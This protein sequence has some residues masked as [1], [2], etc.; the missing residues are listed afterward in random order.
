MNYICLK[1]KKKFYSNINMSVYASNKVHFFVA[2]KHRDNTVRTLTSM[3]AC[4][5]ILV[6]D[7]SEVLVD[8]NYTTDTL[9]IGITKQIINSPLISVFHRQICNI[10]KLINAFEKELHWD[11]KSIIFKVKV[12]STTNNYNKKNNEIYPTYS[13]ILKP[14]K[15]WLCLIPYTHILLSL[16]RLYNYSFDLPNNLNLPII[17]HFFQDI[18]L[19]G[20]D[21]QD[22][23]IIQE[24]FT[25]LMLLLYNMEDLVNESSINEHWDNWW[26]SIGIYYLGCGNVTIPSTD[27]TSINC[28]KLMRESGYLV[29]T[30]NSVYKNYIGKS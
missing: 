9:C 22:L 30:Y 21:S 19:V 5:E 24:H 27:R 16:I 18:T 29:S 1:T 23:C 11:E 3:T 14:N 7:I 26:C 8:L 10:Q 15:N 12:D 25:L 20:G 17:K 13:Y 6:E 4:K 28:V 2:S